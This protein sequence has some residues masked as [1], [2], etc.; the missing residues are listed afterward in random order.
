MHDSAMISVLMPVH[1][2]MPYLPETVES[3]LAQTYHDFELLAIDDGSSD[4]TAQYLRSIQDP[5]VRYHRLSKVGLVEALN[6]GLNKAQ[7]L[8]IARMDADDIA[9]PKRLD[10]QQAYFHEKSDCVL[11]GCD[12]DEIDSLG[13]VIGENDLKMTSDSA[14]RWQML[15]GTPFLHPSVVFPRL[16]ALRAGGYRKVYDTAEDYDM[17]VRLSELGPIASLPDR[18]VRRRSHPS[19]VSTVHRQRGLTQSS[20]IAVGYARKFCDNLD[21][22]AVSDLYWFYQRSREPEHCSMWQVVST[23]NA[24]CELL[25]TNGTE[26]PPDLN[27]AV[28]LARQRLR[29]HCLHHLR[30]SWCRPQQASVWAKIMRAFDPKRG[31]LKSTFLRCLRMKAGFVNH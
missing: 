13:R 14:L 28:D 24:L 7:G 10:R 15:L 2:G 11:L 20:Q 8:L 9:L 4:E 1:N 25:P 23:F 17:W 12:Y 22:V 27:T 3:I 5:R 26:V 18:L 29:R 21:P 6:F 30:G 19:S 16:A 31:T